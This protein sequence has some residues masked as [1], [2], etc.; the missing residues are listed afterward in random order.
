MTNHQTLLSQ[1]FPDIPWQ[2]DKEL[3]AQTYFKLGGSA[4]M[5]WD[6]SSLEQLQEVLLFCSENAVPISLLGGASNVIVADTGIQGLCIHPNSKEWQESQTPPTNPAN[7]RYIA[8]TG[9]QTA[10][11]VRKS[12][13]SN[14]TG[15][16]YF[17]GVPGMLGGAVANNAHYDPF[18]IG[19]FISRVQVLTPRG[20]V[21]W[22]LQSE[23]QFGYDYSRFHASKEVIWAVEF[24]LALGNAERSKEMIAAATRKRAATQPL[25]EPSS[26]CVFQNVPNTP[27]L[28][29]RFPQFKDKTELPTAFL[30]DQAGLKG[31]RRGDIEISTKHA[32]FFINMGAA[33]GTGKSQDVLELIQ[34]VKEKLKQL[35]DVDLKEEVFY[36]Q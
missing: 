11:V 32:A 2:L 12:L 23:C 22:L 26:G 5:Y 7:K 17:L 13:E 8:G 10:L 31:T 1:A 4:E 28:K 35:Y 15:L 20:E 19:Q 3:A 30:I 6:C 21:L 25:G 24:E 16:E 18:L 29:E 34:L 27:E 9:L 33:T 14:L 36:L